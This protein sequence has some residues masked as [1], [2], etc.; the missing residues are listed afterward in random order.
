MDGP[1]YTVFVV[2][3]RK[4]V[5]QRRQVLDGLVHPVVGDV[6]GGRLSAQDQLVADTLLDEAVAIVAADHQVGHVHI[7]DLGLQLAAVLLADLASED[8]SDLVR[9]AD[10]TIG[11]EQ[12]LAKGPDRDRPSRIDR[13]CGLRR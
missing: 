10:R 13:P 4:L 5:A 8:D 2:D 1:G 7:F 6:V 3:R 11:V 12:T 9:L